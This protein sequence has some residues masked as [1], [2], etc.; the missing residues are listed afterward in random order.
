M[1]I[2]MFNLSTFPGDIAKPI[3]ICYNADRQKRDGYIVC[4]PVENPG[5]ATP[6]FSYCM[7]IKKNA[8]FRR[9]YD[10]DNRTLPLHGPTGT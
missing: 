9:S 7:A 3:R 4:T 5:A 1:E 6:G 10:A 2:Y 8:H